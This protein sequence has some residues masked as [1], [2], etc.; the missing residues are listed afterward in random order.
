MRVL[1]KG[2]GDLATGIAYELWEAGAEVLM[3][4][5]AVPLTVRRMVAFSRAIYEGECQVE[6][7]RGCLAHNFAEA[8]QVIK[9]GNIPV[10]VDEKAEI[11]KEYHPDVVVDA[12][13]AKRNIG[14][15]LADASLVIG[16]GPGFCAGED[17]HYVI[18]TQRGEHLGKII[19]KGHAIPNTGIPGN[20]A[21][22]TIE[23][24]LKAPVCGKMKPVAKIGD[25]VAKGQ[26]VAH[27]DNI[28]VKA[29]MSGMIRG[30]LQEGV[31]VKRGMKIGDIDARME[32]SLCYTISDKARHMGRSVKQVFEICGMKI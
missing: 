5:I 3:T 23:R 19:S 30:M 31:I 24:L 14:T 21:G 26:I 1:I 10:I 7:A 20:V 17:C 32:E 6:A 15:L 2:A 29:G 22:Y 25:I 13:M 16:V 12:I 4:E 28:P 9:E 8:M 11:R 18:E 27:I